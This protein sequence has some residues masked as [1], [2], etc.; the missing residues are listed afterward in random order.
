[1]NMNLLLAPVL[2]TVVISELVSNRRMCSHI[3][4]ES[5]LI[6]E[7][8][9]TKADGAAYAN[10]DEVDLAN[11]AIMHLSRRIEYHL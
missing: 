2:I 3:L 6:I 7:G 5:D 9:L 4:E 1:M 8:R 11:N 10:V